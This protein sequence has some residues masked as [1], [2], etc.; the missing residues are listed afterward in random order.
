MRDIRTLSLGMLCV[1]TLTACQSTVQDTG[2]QDSSAAMTDES[3]S[4]DGPYLEID[5]SSS[6]D[7]V[8][9]DVNGSSS[10][11]GDSAAAAGGRVVKVAVSEWAFEPS[12]ITA[13]K[14]EKVTLEL[15][16]VSGIHSFAIP[17]LG[18][19]VRVEPGKTVTVALPTD[20]AGTYE[21]VCRIPCGPGHRDMK[22]TVV[23]S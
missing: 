1:L 13:A 7:S 8:E 5:S 11:A 20:A 9:L 2:D 12:M 14:G 10:S 21:V 23:I 16:G 6:E 22:T 17:E 4:S 15:T 18:M 19:N 3:S